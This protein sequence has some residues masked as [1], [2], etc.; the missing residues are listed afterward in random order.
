MDYSQW[1]RDASTL[2]GEGIEHDDG[3]FR[4]YAVADVDPV[5]LTS[6]ANR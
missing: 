3:F 6:I 1:I 5:P 4:S 2:G